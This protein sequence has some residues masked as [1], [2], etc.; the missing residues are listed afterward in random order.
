MNISRFLSIGFDDVGIKMHE[1][2]I[3]KLTNCPNLGKPKFISIDVLI[4]TTLIND[5]KLEPIY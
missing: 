1:A 3:N 5:T 2:I 4:E